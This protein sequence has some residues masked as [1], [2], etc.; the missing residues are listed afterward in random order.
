MSDIKTCK[1]CNKTKKVSEF[2]KDSSTFDGIRTKCKAC[3]RKVYSNYSE[4]NKKAI[5]NRVQERR[6]LAKYGYTK[7]QLQQMI[8]SGKYKICYSCNMI[9]TLDYFRTTGEGIK[10]TEKCKTCR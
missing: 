9:L 10:F 6:Y 3:Q 1:C 7:E 2:T 8:E 5:A 4:R